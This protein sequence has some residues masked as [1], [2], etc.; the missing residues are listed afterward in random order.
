MRK[1]VATKNIHINQRNSRWEN[2]RTALIR[3]IIDQHINMAYALLECGANPNAPNIKG[4]TSLCTACASLCGDLDLVTKMVLQYGAEISIRDKYGLTPLHYA[5]WCGHV[6]VVK[7]L[8]SQ[9]ARRDVRDN[10]GLTPVERMFDETGPTSTITNQLLPLLDPT[11][12]LRP[13]FAKKKNSVEKN[14]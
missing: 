2:H 14:V 5:A 3:S 10:D 7:F 9:G 6:E 8:L 13:Q 12:E 1:L 11:G 4:Q